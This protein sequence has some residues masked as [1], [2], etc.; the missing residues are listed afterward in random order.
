VAIDHSYS[1]GYSNQT[2]PLSVGVCQGYGTATRPDCAAATAM[3]VAKILSLEWVKIEKVVTRLK[4]ILT[5]EE[6]D[7]ILKLLEARRN[8]LRTF[9]D[10]Q[11]E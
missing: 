4:P 10:L 6:Q 9:L 7:F 2:D 5:S 1:L 3:A 8:H 11:G